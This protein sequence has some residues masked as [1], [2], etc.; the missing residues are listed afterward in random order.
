MNP[1]RRLVLRAPAIDLAR[2]ASWVLNGGAGRPLPPS[3]HPGPPSAGLFL[4][5][6]LRE[7]SGTP[8]QIGQTVA[9]RIC[10]TSDIERRARSVNEYEIRLLN[11]DGT[12]AS[13]A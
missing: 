3:G 5:P 1:R 7:P 11:F 10:Y 6:S 12:Y 4:L 13:I 9:F 2:I 8:C